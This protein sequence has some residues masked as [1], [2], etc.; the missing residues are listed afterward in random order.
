MNTSPAELAS[1]IVDQ[2]RAAGSPE[3]AVSESAYLKSGL[4]FYGVTVWTT[5]RIVREALRERRDLDRVALLALVEALWQEP[6]HEQRMAAYEALNT[7]SP[8]LAGEDLALVERLIRESKTWALV[9]GLAEHVAGGL[10]QRFPEL[11][12]TL[13]RWAGDPDFWLRRA[14]LL[15][16]LTPLRRG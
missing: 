2:L 3:R 9:D 13:D 7:C 15:A 8:L 1:R 6:I 4:K 11:N 5:R 10:V 12:A 16:L 14:A